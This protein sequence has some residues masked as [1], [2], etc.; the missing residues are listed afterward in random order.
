MVKIWSLPGSRYVCSDR[1]MRSSQDPHSGIS[2]TPRSYSS[3]QPQ[4]R[5]HTTLRKNLS[6][7][8]LKPY[9]HP[10]PTRLWTECSSLGDFIDH[11]GQIEAN[12]FESWNL[13]RNSS[14]SKVT[15]QLNNQ[16]GIMTENPPACQSQPTRLNSGG[17]KDQQIQNE[18]LKICVYSHPLHHFCQI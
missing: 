18:Q 6:P 16:L 13:L 15:L 9:N 8:N 3:P 11:H 5:S 14:S 12:L 17:Y 2:T 4:L 7:R 1:N 10:E